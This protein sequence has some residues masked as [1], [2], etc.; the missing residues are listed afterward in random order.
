MSI[1][2]NR[3]TYTAY[4]GR[5]NALASEMLLTKLS[6]HSLQ[7]GLLGY[8][9]RFAPLALVLQRPYQPSKVLSPIG[10]LLIY[11]RISSLHIKF[12]LPLLNASLVVFNA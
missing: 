9:I 7:L 10:V 6:I 12:P 11:L 4:I 1:I 3:I 5:N 2:I 8:L